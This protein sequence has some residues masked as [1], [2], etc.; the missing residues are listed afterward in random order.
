[1]EK[2]LFCFF[3]NSTTSPRRKKCGPVRNSGGLLHIVGHH[4]DGIGLFFSSRAN[5]STL[6][7]EIGS[8]ALVGS[9]IR[10]TSGWTARALAIQILC[11]CPPES[12]SALFFQA[13]LYFIPDGC[14]AKRI[15]YQLIQLYFGADPVCPGTVGNIII[16]YS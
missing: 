4:N 14:S 13:V 7:V 2:N 12:P 6:A 3:P 10:R 1:M 8:S 5:S 11:C 15:L 9:S 16:N